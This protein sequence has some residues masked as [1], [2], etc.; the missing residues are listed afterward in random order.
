MKI[1]H[2]CLKRTFKTSFWKF[3]LIQA[4]LNNA[5]IV[6]FGK[7]LSIWTKSAGSNWPRISSPAI[8]KRLYFVQD[9]KRICI[10]NCDMA[11]ITKD[12]Y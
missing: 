10:D 8:Y 11:E 6:P 1:S 2:N 7:H 3:E 12:V 9:N 4:Y 5:G